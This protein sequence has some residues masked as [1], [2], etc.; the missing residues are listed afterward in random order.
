[1]HR[2]GCFM[3]LAAL[4]AA[5]STTVAEGAMLIEPAALEQRLGEPS[6]RIL[7]TRSKAEYDKGHIPGALRVDVADWRDLGRREGG[8]HDAKAWAER[9][10]K[11]GI[12]SESHVVVYG[13]RLPDTARI[14]WLL[15]Y[16]GLPHVAILDGGWQHWAD[17]GR[18]ISRETPQVVPSRFRPEFQSDRLAEI[19]TLKEALRTG[20]ITLVDTRSRAEFTGEVN[21]GKRPGHIPGAVHLEWKELLQPD[22][23]FKSPAELRRLFAE[24]G[25]KPEK[26]TACY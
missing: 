16:V 7:D 2:G 19:D 1:M 9:I 8:L 18:P 22:G 6:L 3:L 26:T 15:K 10:R 17:Q 21:R 23:R 12:D 14:W 13:S 20:D 11:L 5:T 24:R 25:I 4:T